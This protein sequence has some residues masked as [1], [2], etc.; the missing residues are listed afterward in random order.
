MTWDIR[1]PSI[2]LKAR[3]VVAIYPPFFYAGK[4]KNR[5]WLGGGR[6]FGVTTG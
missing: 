4:Y 5:V 1:A 2:R 6:D 3:K